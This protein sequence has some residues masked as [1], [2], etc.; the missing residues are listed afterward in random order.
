MNVG[1]INT[2]LP[3]LSRVI[4]PLQEFSAQAIDTWIGQ[5]PLSDVDAACAAIQHLL[6]TINMTDGL[7]CLERQRIVEQLRPPTVSLL[8]MSSEQHLPSSTLFPL[9]RAQRQF[10]Q[11]N[12]EICME[13][14]NA[15]RRVIT[16]GTFF[17]DKVMSEN[18][19]AHIVY[20]ALQAYGLA[21]LRSLE[22]YE[23][24][25]EGFWLE[26]YAIYRFAEGHRLHNL[27]LPMPE[28]EGATVDSQF[29]QMLLLALSSH[30]H[31]PPDEIRQFYTMLML[32]AKDAEILSTPEWNN[33]TALYCFD[34][35]SDNPPKS[36]KRAKPMPQAG[37]RCYVFINPMLTK[38]QQYFSNPAH[39]ATERFKL[40]PST[41][42]SLLEKLSSA[43]KRR[44]VRKPASGIKR[45]TVGLHRVIDALS[46]TNSSVAEIVPPVEL[47]EIDEFE[48]I[49]DQNS[50]NL[51]GQPKIN[52]YGITPDNQNKVADIPANVEL[53]GSLINISAGG[54]CM[55]WLNM[56]VPGARVGELIGTYENISAARVGELI[57]T[58]EEGEQNIHIG[59]IRWMHH[60]KEDELVIG[61]EL[62]SPEVEAV[63][64]DTGHDREIP[65]RGLYLSAHP[66]LGLPASLLCAPGIV[67][68]RQNI[69][70]RGKQGESRFHLERIVESSLSFQLFTL[71]PPVSEA[72]SH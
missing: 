61:V 45:F 58:Y 65:L 71:V 26:V 69:V 20:R 43:E 22:R 35:H 50:N 42:L 31:H 46:G 30:Q 60:M 23:A 62:S 2:P 5:L 72:N 27:N 28:I 53:T 9:P 12:V 47:E 64:I 32:I 41:I 48:I 7:E 34:M 10:T 16:S 51:W 36:V 49:L 15:Y 39:R 13:L 18:G 6:R 59:I 66:K 11:R 3:T 68:A 56:Q 40:R 38:A 52:A 33:E 24:P 44:F 54:Y 25:P 29:K 4:A 67:K 21:L 70:L 14:A 63:I 57:G 19:R 37:E 1:P 8:G 55:S 17:S